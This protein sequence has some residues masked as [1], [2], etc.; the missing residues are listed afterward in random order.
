[1]TPPADRRHLGRLLRRLGSSLAAASIL[2]AAWPVLTSASASGGASVRVPIAASAWYWNRQLSGVGAPGAP[3]TQ[4]RDPTVPSG[5]LAVAGPSQS[6]QPQ[7]ETYLSFGLDA[8]PAGAQILSFT[9]T[10]PVDP[11][12]TNVVPTGIAAPIIACLPLQSWAAGGPQPFSGKPTDQCT[13]TSP[14]VTTKDGGKTYTVDIASIAQQWLAG[15][16]SNVGVA[17]TDDPSNTSSAYQVVFGPPSALQKLQASATYVPAVTATTSVPPVAS[18]SNAAP[19]AATASQGVSAPAPT[20]PSNPAASLPSSSPG[21]SASAPATAPVPQAGSPTPSTAPSPAAAR[22]RESGSFLPAGFWVAGLVLALML[23][24]SGA[25]L[26]SPAEGAARRRTGGLG[27]LLASRNTSL[28]KP[29]T[30]RV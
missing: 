2:A 13:D 27:R 10:L 21:V 12:G 26:S 15:S 6:G 22:L 4:L 7:K 19:P 11:A 20:V 8:I 23:V 16:G 28:R 3:P 25:V 5:D 18:G 1:V 14:K 24:V 9:V 29:S 17:I 30:G